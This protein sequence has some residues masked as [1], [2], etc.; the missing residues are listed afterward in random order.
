MTIKEYLA[1]HHT[2]ML[3]LE[4]KAGL[5]TATLSKY[6]LGETK[7]LSPKTKEKLKLLGIEEPQRNIPR[8][9]N[10]YFRWKEN[11]LKGSVAEYLITNQITIT[12]LARR[13]GVSAAVLSQ[14]LNGITGLSAHNRQ[15]LCALGV[16]NFNI[17]N[18]NKRKN[19]LPKDDE[20]VVTDTIQ[21]II[22]EKRGIAYVFN[23]IQKN[24]LIEWLESRNYKFVCKKVRKND[25]EIHFKKV[26][27]ED[28]K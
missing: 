25:Y 5:P 11:P 14:H 21:Y 10:R 19:K 3:Q 22:E 13:S 9:A 26:E 8:K 16:T 15:R 20:T 17:S 18:P 1:T 27:K 7:N 28:E 4:S 2:N 6:F 24:E 23:K 12:E